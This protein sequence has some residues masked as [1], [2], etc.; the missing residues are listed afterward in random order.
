MVEQIVGAIIDACML[1][2]HAGSPDDTPAREEGRTK[3]GAS[4]LL[5][6]VVQEIFSKECQTCLPERHASPTSKDYVT[7]VDGAYR[8]TGTRISLDSVAYAFLDGHTSESIGDSFPLLT[9]E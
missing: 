2:C 9:L 5:S 4:D 6:L 3:R 8:I 1:R 7:Q